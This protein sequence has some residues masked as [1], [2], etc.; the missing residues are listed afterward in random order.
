MFMRY[1]NSRFMQYM[2]EYMYRIYLTDGIKHICGF[3]KRWHDMVNYEPAK[4]VEVNPEEIKNTI[5]S[6]LERLSTDG[7]GPI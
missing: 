1:T 7:N 5:K 4:H 3:N 6:K 2:R